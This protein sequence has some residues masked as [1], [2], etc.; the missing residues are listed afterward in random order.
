MKILFVVP[1]VPNPIRV[2]PYELLRTLA[3]RGHQITLATLWQNTAEA[4]E[5]AA[6][7][8]LGITVIAEPLSKARAL[9]NSALALPTRRPLQARYCWQPALAARLE[10]LVAEQSFDVAHVEH[11]R[12]AAYGLLLQTLATPSGETLP[13]VWDS[14]DCISHLFAQAARQSRSRSGRLMTM[15]EL[16]RT[17]RHEGWLL[18][19][20]AQVLVTSE[21]DQ[22][23]LCALAEQQSAVA[24]RRGQPPRRPDWVSPQPV[25]LPNG[26]DLAHFAQGVRPSS[27]ADAGTTPPATVLFSGKMSY[28]ANVT[29]ALYLVNEIMPHVW[30]THPAVRVQIVGKDPPAQIRA[31]ATTNASRAAQA[32]RGSVEVTGTVPDI[33]P[34][35]QQATV[36]AAPLLYG[37]G[38]QNKVLEAMACGTP[39]VTTGQAAGGMQ[40]QPGRDL[41]VAESAPQ[42]A[43]AIVQLLENADERR[44]LRNAGRAYVEAHHSWPAIVAALETVYCQASAQRM[45]ATPPFFPMSLVAN[46]RGNG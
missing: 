20:F 35:I 15:L 6:L 45:R 37:A 3:A 42:F 23:A 29:A 39:V 10:R 36:A 26:V 16:A 14:V 43:T 21:P 7:A 30:A 27:S 46:S 9:W 2:R 34:Y 1:Y 28:H 40:A 13:V 19:Q 4:R 44:A 38:I 25:V 17:Q 8:A 11:L 22:Q 18:H 41:L 32:G 24:Q 5:I 12:G 33:R 31:L